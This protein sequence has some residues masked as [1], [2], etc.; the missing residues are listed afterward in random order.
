VAE[1]APAQQ[2]RALFAVFFILFVVVIVFLFLL[3]LFAR[4]QLEAVAHA[5]PAPGVAHAAGGHAA[6]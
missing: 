1:V 5:R 3:F 2:A 4:A 6:R